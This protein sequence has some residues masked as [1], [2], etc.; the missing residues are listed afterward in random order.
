MTFF[1]GLLKNDEPSRA[2]IDHEIL[3]L[4]SKTLLAGS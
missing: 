4:I 3:E 1:R 2:Q